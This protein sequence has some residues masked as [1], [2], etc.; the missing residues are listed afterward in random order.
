MD[1][2]K[3]GTGESIAAISG[4]VLLVVM[5]FFPWFGVST[6][7]IPINGELPSADAWQAFTLID[8]FL[9]LTVLVAVGGAVM[10][11]VSRSVNTPVAIST[12][13]C[14]FGIAS[15]VLILFRI[16][17]P[18]ELVS[19]GADLTSF[20]DTTREVGVF[21]GLVAA[22]GIVWGSW[23]AMRDEGTG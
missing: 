3:P 1:A 20:F 17:F 22:A 8:L 6:A 23:I 2:T 13:T 5:F 4:L 21:L 14:W 15:V 16:A 9:L 19:A 18:P 10:A 11:A 12:M 7:G